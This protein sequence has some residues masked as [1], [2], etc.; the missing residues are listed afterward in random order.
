MLPGFALR[1]VALAASAQKN[2]LPCLHAC[3][4][5]AAAATGR[6][7][8]RAHAGRTRARLWQLWAVPLHCPHHHPPSMQFFWFQTTN[9]TGQHHLFCC[10]LHTF[11]RTPLPTLP[12]CTTRAYRTH[13]RCLPATTRRALSLTPAFLPC[14]CHAALPSL[15]LPCTTQA[16]AHAISFQRTF[17]CLPSCLHHLEYGRQRDCKHTQPPPLSLSY[18]SASLAPA[19]HSPARGRDVPLRHGKFRR[20]AARRHCWRGHRTTTPTCAHCAKHAALPR[21]YAR[22]VYVL[23]TILP[24]TTH[25][26]SVAY[27][28]APLAAHA[29]HAGWRA[30]PSAS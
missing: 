25:L 13:L 5:L 19:T 22:C 4:S 6:L 9:K 20:I 8:R 16:L 26:S 23:C 10:T 7:A 15:P 28:A 1:F 12:F 27:R 14:F 21:C 11:L 24:R 2:L 3:H 17:V 18:S 30:S 29:A